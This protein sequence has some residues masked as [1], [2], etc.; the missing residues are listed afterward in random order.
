[1]QEKL[2]VVCKFGLGDEFTCNK[3]MLWKENKSYY[4]FKL[5]F[6]IFGN[7]DIPPPALSYYSAGIFQVYIKE[8]S[9]NFG[10]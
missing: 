10:F 6:T 1:M 5:Q 9:K 2:A 4:S 3:P 8:N 7:L